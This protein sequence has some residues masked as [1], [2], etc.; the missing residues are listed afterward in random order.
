MS[1]QS[2]SGALHALFFSFYEVR[3]RRVYKSTLNGEIA[4]W[5]EYICEIDWNILCVTGVRE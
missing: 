2:Q 5:A 4:S 1:E 3:L